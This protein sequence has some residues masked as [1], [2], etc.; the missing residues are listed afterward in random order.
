MLKSSI[1]SLNE[2]R[3][4][5]ARNVEYLKETAIDDIVDE[6]TEAAESTLVGE[7][8]EELNEALEMVNI[9]IVDSDDEL[10]L[11]SEEIQRIL[12]AE[13]NISFNEMIGLD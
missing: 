11:E 8:M 13:D 1:D 4:K 3:A 9:M 5:F 2:S 12:D 7:T 6:R 10:A